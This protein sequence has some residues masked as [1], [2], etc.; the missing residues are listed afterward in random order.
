[1][2][3]RLT[4]V[5]VLFRLW[6]LF[7]NSLISLGLKLCVGIFNFLFFFLRLLSLSMN[8][9]HPLTIN[10]CFLKYILLYYCLFRSQNL[11]HKPCILWS[12]F[13]MLCCLLK[14]SLIS[15]HWFRSHN[16]QLNSVGNLYMDR[17]GCYLAV[18]FLVIINLKWIF[19]DNFLLNF[20]MKNYWLS[21]FLVLFFSNEVVS[22]LLTIC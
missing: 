17:F 13:S 3:L 11:L 20:L 10:I 22:Y 1:M 5:M 9:V 16:G 6:V 15:T 4:G 2:L 12:L 7:F 8:V 18:F 19:W 21:M 14:Y